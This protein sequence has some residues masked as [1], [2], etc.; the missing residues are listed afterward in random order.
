MSEKFISIFY[1]SANVCLFIPISDG[2]S[3]PSTYSPD[4]AG[5]GYDQ[6]MHMQGPGNYQY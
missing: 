4:G 1:V 5:M 3:G 2:F 6:R